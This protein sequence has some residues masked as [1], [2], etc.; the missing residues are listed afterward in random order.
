MWLWLLTGLNG[1]QAQDCPTPWSAAQVSEW[2]GRAEAA[3]SDLDEKGF[4][5]AVDQIT[6]ALPCVSEAL[7]PEHAAG[8]H[9]IQALAANAQG[10][11]GQARSAL[12]ASRRAHPEGAFPE[13]LLGAGHPLYAAVA[14]PL[15]TFESVAVPAPVEGSVLLDGRPDLERALGLPTV[16]QRLRDDGGVAQTLYVA[17]DDAWP[18]YAARSAVVDDA[19]GADIA[20]RKAG[21]GQKI[22]RFSSLAV[23]GAAIGLYGGAYAM[24]VKGRSDFQQSGAT[25]VP[26]VLPPDLKRANAVAGTAVG[27][28]ALAAVGFGVSFAGEF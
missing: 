22:L 19:A 6:L 26:S 23:G 15:P 14:E 2:V 27:L 9:R 8:V 25:E 12:L 20:G 3:F 28:G 17:V 4:F 16:F 7:A 18:A 24:A 11:R 1:A 10:Q 21:K 5:L 13:G